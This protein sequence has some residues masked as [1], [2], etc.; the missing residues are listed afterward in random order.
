[1]TPG[2]AVAAFRRAPPARRRLAL[3]ALASLAV[4]RVLTAMPA[5]LY[6]RFLGRLC[7]AP[8]RVGECPAIARDIGSVTARVAECVPF[9]A[10]CLE[11]AIATRRMLARRGIRAT[12]TFGVNRD[13]A[14]R[15]RPQD[16]DAAH[17]WVEVGSRIVAGDGKLDQFLVVA[18]FS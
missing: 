15:S 8:D 11:Q 2:D 4:A 12:V 14:T 3:E 6:T 16:G 7:A 18:R 9:R 1:M 5:C 17:A 13:A 10:R